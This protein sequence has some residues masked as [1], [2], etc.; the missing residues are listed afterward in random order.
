MISKLD[1]QRLLHQIDGD[2]PILSLTLDMS[3]NEEN[4]RTYQ[5]F[6]RQAR[7]DYL[8][9]GGDRPANRHDKL[10]A[11]F[12]RVQGWIDE[13]FDPANKGAAI[14]T[15]IDGEWVFGLQFPV[16]VQNNAVIGDHP[17]LGGLVGLL[18]RP[19]HYGVIVVDR[20]SLRLIDL[21]LGTPVAEHEVKT[22]PYPTPGDI[23]AGGEA[24]AGYQRHKLDEMRGF[25]EVF[26]L[27]IEAFVEL[28]RPHGLILMGTEDNM[29]RFSEVL[30]LELREMIVHREHAPVVPTGAA[31]AERLAPFLEEH[32][33][34]WEAKVIDTLRD[35][36]AGGFH[37]VAGLQETLE[38]L[39]EGKVDTLVLGD[40]LE[41][42]GQFCLN[43]H[44][45]L[46]NSDQ[47]CQYCGGQVEPDIDLVEAM[48]R[49]A[50]EQD[51][52]IAIV[53]PTALSDLGNTGGLLRY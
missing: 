44:F 45:Y 42:T 18:G 33:L 11:A 20:E 29:K 2:E 28:Y 22:R 9:L 53:D 30:P 19:H 43:C 51:V 31:V 5:I 15:P 23:K 38:R 50:A 36:V 24:S 49:V 8:G 34:E 7:S 3:V 10:G 12:D 4:K 25:F 21:R 47:V 37:A 1:I 16:P 17:H 35:R 13:E 41:E 32:A 27:E 26:A 6:L 14:Y 46:A 52:E 48:L 40:R 39:Q